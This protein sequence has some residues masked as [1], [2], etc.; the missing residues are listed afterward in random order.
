MKNNYIAITLTVLTVVIQSCSKE[1]EINLDTLNSDNEL[2]NI[3]VI[4]NKLK[5]ESSESLVSFIEQKDEEELKGEIKGL[6]EKG[7]NSLAPLFDENDDEAIDEFLA[8]KQSKIAE[9]GYL[10][11]L[12][13]SDEIDTEDELISDTRFASILNEDREIYVGD[14]YY[15]YTTTGLYFCKIED[16]DYLKNYLNELKGTTASK[17]TFLK[18][19]TPAC[20]IEENHLAKETSKTSINDELTLNPIS[21]EV[22]P[23]DQKINYFTTCGNGQQSSNGGT[24]TTTTTTSAP[25]IPMLIPQNFGTCAYSENSLFQQVFGNTVKCND[26]HDST[27]R[28]QTKV[29]NE[30]Y[31]IFAT[32]GVSAKYQKKRFIGWSE[33]VTSDEVRLGINHAIYTYKSPISPYNPFDPSRVVVKYKGISYD[34]YGNIVQNFPIEPNAWPYAQN[35][36]VGEVDIEIFGAELYYPLTGNQAN[37]TINQL[38]S[39]IRSNFTGLGNDLNQDKVGVNIIKFLPN[40]FKIVRTDIVKKHSSQV[41]ETFDVNFLLTLKNSSDLNFKTFTDQINS[42]KYD[43]LDIDI[44]GAALRNGVWKG[45]RIVGKIK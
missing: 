6:S 16:E 8:Q 19:A 21:G 39:L 7:F 10:Y 12:K 27:H 15:V 3:Q 26:Y 30:N 34:L 35:E 33:S 20:I 45:K 17:S 32:V 31:L 11:S 44:Y 9:K 14:N 18:L 22:M 24:T 41:K 40:E 36:T 4:D 13:E 29:W 28:I 42:E 37:S 38:L 2:T 23:I 43:D 1:K 5:F 25:V